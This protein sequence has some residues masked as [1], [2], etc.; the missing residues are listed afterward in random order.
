MY[1]IRIYNIEYDYADIKGGI[2]SKELHYLSK[3][4]F[5]KLRASNAYVSNSCTFSLTDF[6]EET[7]GF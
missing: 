3:F 6:L 7:E 4:S 2:K 5:K 1:S